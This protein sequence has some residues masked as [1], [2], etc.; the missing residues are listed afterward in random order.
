MEKEIESINDEK[1]QE[2]IPGIFEIFSKYQ[3]NLSEIQALIYETLFTLKKSGAYD[4][5]DMLTALI[6]VQYLLAKDRETEIKNKGPIK[7]GAH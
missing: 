5:E 6:N 1:M 2:I 3:V 4:Y 7:R